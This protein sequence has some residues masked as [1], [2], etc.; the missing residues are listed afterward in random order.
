MTQEDKVYFTGLFKGLEGRFDGLEAKVEQNSRDIRANGM[1]I[2][3]MR[4]DISHI[5]E[6]DFSYSELSAKVEAMYNVVMIDIPA[7]RRAVI[8]HGKRITALEA[9]S[10]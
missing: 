7:I 2:E 6:R 9:K 1:A 4:D 3:L 8:D 10:G 5:S